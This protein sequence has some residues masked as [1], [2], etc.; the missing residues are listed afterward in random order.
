MVGGRTLEYCTPEEDSRDTDKDLVGHSMSL[1][2]GVVGGSMK[3]CNSDGVEHVE[4]AEG[5]S[6]SSED[7]AG[8]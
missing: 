1:C 6:D 5:G 4:E 8:L 7:S 3:A 2:E